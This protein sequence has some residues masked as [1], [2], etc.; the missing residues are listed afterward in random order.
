MQGVSLAMRYNKEIG[1]KLNFCIIGT[2]PISL[3]T[4]EKPSPLTW[5]GCLNNK[6]EKRIEFCIIVHDLGGQVGN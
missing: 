4:L 5:L 1:E 3:A 6:E 2:I